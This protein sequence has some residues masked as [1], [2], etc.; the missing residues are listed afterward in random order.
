M[1]F[2]YVNVC[3]RGSYDVPDRLSALDAFAFLQSQYPH[4]AFRLV[5]VNVSRSE[6]SACRSHRI[7]QLIRPAK[8][9]L[10][11]SI[12]CVLWFAARASGILHPCNTPFTFVSR[13]FREK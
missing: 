7:R 12:G 6:L 1:Y 3:L 10:D 13:L 8:T 5:K 2:E 4:V 9:V 11:D